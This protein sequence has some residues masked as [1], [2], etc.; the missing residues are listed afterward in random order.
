MKYNADYIAMY[1]LRTTK[2]YLYGRDISIQFEISNKKWN[3]MQN[4]RN[5]KSGQKYAQNAGK[6]KK[7]DIMPTPLKIK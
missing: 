2:V 1:S 3:I 7:K 4:F 5:R 6:I